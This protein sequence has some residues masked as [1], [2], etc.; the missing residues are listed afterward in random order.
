MILN[1]LVGERLRSTM[2][3]IGRGQSILQLKATVIISGES[4]VIVE[5]TPITESFSFVSGRRIES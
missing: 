2:K 1:I 3:I 5:Y 4:I